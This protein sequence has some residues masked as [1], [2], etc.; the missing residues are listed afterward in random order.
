M[1]RISISNEVSDEPYKVE[2]IHNARQT[3]FEKQLYEPTQN[4]PQI[5]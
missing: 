1:K 2:D 5:G 4:S 3:D